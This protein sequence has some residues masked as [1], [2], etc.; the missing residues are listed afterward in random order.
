MRKTILLIEG[1]W[2]DRAL[3][4]LMF[5]EAGYVVLHALDGAEALA[6]FRRH[7]S[8]IAVAVLG[9]SQDNSEELFVDGVQKINQA[10]P[11]VFKSG[12]LWTCTGRFRET[13]RRFRPLA[14]MAQVRVFFEDAEVLKG[15]PV[16]EASPGLFT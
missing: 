9:D 4:S 8:K 1:S 16:L 13:A 6:M 10:L 2:E 14:L 11:I 12:E 3:L 5:G 7:M 15:R